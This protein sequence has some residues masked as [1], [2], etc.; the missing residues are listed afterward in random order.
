MIR[1]HRHTPTDRDLA[2]FADGSLSAARRG[3]VEQALSDS[4][5]LRASVAA[6]R[7]VLTAID[8]ASTGRAPASLRARVALAQPPAR[9]S[10]P[11]RLG[12][13]LGTALVG[14]GA[15]AVVAVV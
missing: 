10:R 15:A 6:Q 5:Q 3:Q 12:A 13:V 1:R 2:A 7:R 8:A 11:S 9:R 4:P 14:A